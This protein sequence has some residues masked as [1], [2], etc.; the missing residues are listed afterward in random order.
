MH[1][2]GEDGQKNPSVRQKSKDFKGLGKQML[3]SF[4]NSVVGDY[5]DKF[6][7]NKLQFGLVCFFFL[8]LSPIKMFLQIPSHQHQASLTSLLHQHRLQQPKAEI[9]IGTTEILKHL[10]KAIL[11]NSLIV[12]I[13]FEVMTSF[14]GGK[15]QNKNAGR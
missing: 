8:N 13:P 1:T 15:T 10:R 9:F 14:K 3:V 6:G 5:L 4:T 7:I 2:K 12:T 11:L